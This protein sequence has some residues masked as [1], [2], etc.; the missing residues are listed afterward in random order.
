MF[1]RITASVLFAC[2]TFVMGVAAV[3]THQHHNAPTH[4]VVS[5]VGGHH[6]QVSVCA[7]CKVTKERAEFSECN[8][9]VAWVQID[10]CTPPIVSNLVSDRCP[11][12]RTGRAPPQG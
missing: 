10:K 7:L 12:E 6:E 2:M 4:D 9:E 5:A 11:Q 1:L 3:H 8:L